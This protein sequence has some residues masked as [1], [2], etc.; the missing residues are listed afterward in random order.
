[1]SAV[2]NIANARYAKAVDAGSA[3]AYADVYQTAIPWKHADNTVQS[4]TIED[5]V[6]ALDNTMTQIGSVVGAV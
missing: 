1:M 6:T 3:T 5:L 2:I 4:I